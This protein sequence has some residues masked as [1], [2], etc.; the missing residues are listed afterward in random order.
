M[1]ADTT[2]TTFV[3]SDG[4]NVVIQDWPLEPGVHLR[5]VVILVHG[6]G[7]HAGRYDH[8]A[9]QLN[10]W[11]FA[12]RGYDQCGHGESGGAPGSLPTDTRLLD[13]LADIVDSTRARMEKS[14]PLI[15]LGHSMGGLVAGR[16]VSLGIRPVDALV[17]SSPA[18]NPGLSGFQK[19]LVAVLPKFFPNLRVGN[20]LNANYISHD[21]AVVA[22]YQSDRLVHDRISAR[23]ARFIATAGPAT[24]AL[25]PQWKVPTL[26][27]YAGDDRLVQP[28]GSRDFAAAAPAAVV[29]TRCF[30]GLYHEIF[31]ELDATPVFAALRQWLD[32]RF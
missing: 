20:G 3:A 8:V 28:Q 30:E 32:Q 29:T 24:V 21:P 9:R 16:F 4:D 19:L 26:L 7:E 23:L 22:A 6:L 18:L 12:V 11:G 31:N 25:A 2:L 10:D 27:M 1:C 14:T 13:D 15:V 5:G 17:M